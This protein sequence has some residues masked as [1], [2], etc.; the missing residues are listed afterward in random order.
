MTFFKRLTSLTLSNR[1][2]SQMVDFSSLL[3][4][5]AGEAKKPEALAA[6]NYPGVIKSY[7]LGDQ[8]KNKTPYVRLAL[9]LT[10][11][12][13]G[14]EPQLD[15]KGEPVDLSKR[16]LRRD[17][18]LTDDA[19]FRLDDLLRSCNIA[20]EGRSYEETLPELVGQPVIVEVQQYMN[21]S[22][23]DIGNQVGSLAG[24]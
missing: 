8:N 6:G 7:E 21:Q 24:A 2:H 16:G 12:P 17:Y 20:V 14:A 23:N 4:K 22:T 18:F 9:G 3:K 10:G 11:W 15:A 1:K 13:D 5:P 19:L